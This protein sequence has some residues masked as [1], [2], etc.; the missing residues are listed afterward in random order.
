[1]N[2]AGKSIMDKLISF[3]EGMNLMEDPVT[4]F[5]ISTGP[6]VA[7]YAFKIYILP[8]FRKDKNPSEKDR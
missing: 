2:N 8:L 4:I 5:F 3:L 7:Y 1:M 6:I